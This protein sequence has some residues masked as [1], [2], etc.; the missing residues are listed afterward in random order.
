L[1]SHGRDLFGERAIA[2][3]DIKN[4]LSG[5]GIEQIKGDSS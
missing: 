3:A 5:L 2:A 4:S 1:S